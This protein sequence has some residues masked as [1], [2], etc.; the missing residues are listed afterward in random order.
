[1]HRILAITLTVAALVLPTPCAAQTDVN[2]V[3]A[4]VEAHNSTLK[5]L[6]LTL[7]AE[8]QANHAETTLDDPEIEVAQQWGSPSSIGTRQ[9][10]NVSQRFDAA[11]LTGSKRRL[12]GARDEEAR[13]R[14]ALERSRIMLDAREAIAD[15]IYYNALTALLRTRLDQARV[16]SRAWQQRHAA[17]RAS[18]TDVENSRLDLQ[19]A[20]T[21]MARTLAE[22]TAAQQ[23]LQ[24]LCGDQPVTLTDTAFAAIAPL[25]TFDEWAARAEAQGPTLAYARSQSTV[26]QQERRVASRQA[27]P[28][29]TLGYGGE[30]T[31]D[32]K[33]QGL[34]VGLSLPLWSARRRVRSAKA[35]VAAAEAQATDARAATMAEVRR[36]YDQVNALQRVAADSD[37][38]LAGQQSLHLWQRS[39]QEGAISVIDYLTAI[40]LY[41][42][43]RQQ[44]LDTRRDLH[45]AYARLL[46]VAGE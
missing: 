31:R 1:M 10:L 45:K 28:A 46:V 32:E 18:L 22:R 33:Y 34:T 11:T 39:L 16:T 5:A 35:A 24:W 25:G 26:A 41:Y 38:N 40:R 3:L 42:D 43:A 2:A 36:L 44:N 19:M 13:Q 14:Y 9:N 7:D 6:R 37:R 12:A 4:T 15:V 21:D 23:R 30:F 27:L 8:Q 29:L 17:G 20:E